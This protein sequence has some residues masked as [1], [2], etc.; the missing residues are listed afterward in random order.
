MQAAFDNAW[1]VIL[2]RED[3]A[4]EIYDAG[5]VLMVERQEAFAERTSRCEDALAKQAGGRVG[6]LCVASYGRVV[7]HSSSTGPKR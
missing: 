4:P 7:A 2:L 3:V 1:G 5:H 6:D